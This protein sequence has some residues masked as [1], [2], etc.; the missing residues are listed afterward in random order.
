MTPSP[1][2]GDLDRIDLFALTVC[3]EPQWSL[4]GPTI[5][6]SS[7]IDM[8]IL[9]NIYRLIYYVFRINRKVKFIEEMITS[10]FF[11]KNRVCRVIKIII[12]HE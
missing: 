3:V 11:I 5:L 7:R 2:K 6:P 12:S 1:F 4:K 8:S 10:S 9:L